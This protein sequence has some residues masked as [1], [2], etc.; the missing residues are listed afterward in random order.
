MQSTDTMQIEATIPVS[1]M[2][3][4]IDVH[5]IQITE[6]RLKNILFENETKVARKNDWIAPL[7]IFISL[8]LAILTGDPKE[9][10]GLSGDVWKALFVICCIISFVY[11]LKWFK[12]RDDGLSIDALIEKIKNQKPKK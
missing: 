10:I 3:T 11:L 8:L 9:F 2:S 12:N 7:G 5:L 1:G 4:N 6:D